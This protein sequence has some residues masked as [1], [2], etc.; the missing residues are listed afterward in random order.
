VQRRLS[1]PLGTHKEGA[2]ALTWE[3]FSEARGEDGLV[4][5]V[6]HGDKDALCGVRMLAGDIRGRRRCP[7]CRSLRREAIRKGSGEWVPK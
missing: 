7:K 5:V 2:V 3:S 4:H 6:K 1:E